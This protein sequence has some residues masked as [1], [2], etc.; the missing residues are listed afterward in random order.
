MC[1]VTW[2]EFPG[3]PV[4]QQGKH[5]IFRVKMSGLYQRNSQFPGQQEL[6]VLYLAGDKGIGSLFQ[7][8]FQIISASA[9]AHSHGLYRL[10]SGSITDCPTA[11]RL[12]Y[13]GSKGFRRQ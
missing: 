4:C 9:A 13:M 10:M 1:Q 8:S 6:M 2:G 7:S 11:Q 12:L 5:D 3:Q